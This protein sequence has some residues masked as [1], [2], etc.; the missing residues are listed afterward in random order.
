M[1]ESLTIGQ[2]ARTAGVPST[3]AIGVP[4]P[5]R[6]SAPSAASAPRATLADVT[7]ASSL[8][9][10]DAAHMPLDTFTAVRR[11]LDG[12]RALPAWSAARPQTG[13]P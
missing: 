4:A 12:I 6:T 2:V 8:L 9:Y 1:S 7:I 13:A 3:L 11:W 5:N 10:A